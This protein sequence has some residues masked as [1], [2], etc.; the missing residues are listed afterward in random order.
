MDYI[1]EAKQ[2][3][4]RFIGTRAIPEAQPEPEP[5]TEYMANMYTVMNTFKGSQ[6]EAKAIDIA[7]RKPEADY[8][9]SSRA[10][11]CIGE[12]AG[13]TVAVKRWKGRSPPKEIAMFEADYLRTAAERRKAKTP[14]FTFGMEINGEYV[15]ITE[16]LSQGGKYQLVDLYDL[17]EIHGFN[18]ELEEQIQMHLMGVAEVYGNIGLNPELCWRLHMLAGETPPPPVIASN[19]FAVMEGDTV[20]N[21]VCADVDQLFEL[22]KMRAENGYLARVARFPELLDD[23]LLK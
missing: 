16:D 7:T 6:L 14:E 15:L 21:L 3:L 18:D 13:T 8:T 9:G 19:S 17:H 1:A 22:E 4:Q 10:V 2:L 20:R 23:L 12:L 5:T 11:H